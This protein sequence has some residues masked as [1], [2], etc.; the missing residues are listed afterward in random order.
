MRTELAR[1]R[2]RMVAEVTAAGRP[3]SAPVTEAL[4]VVA[5]HLFLP[6]MPPEVAYRDD[7]IVTRRG[8]DGQPTSSS[9]QPTIMAIMLDQLGLEPGQRVLEIGA[10]TGYNAALMKYLVGPSGT[11]V[12]VDLDQ[13]VAREAAAH[14]AAAGYPE[15][16]VAAGDGAEGYPAGA[17]YDR[18]IATVGVSDLAPAWLD[19]L[20]PDG[21]I[22]VPLDLRGS[23][24]SIAFERASEAGVAGG[25]P[26][27]DDVPG[28]WQSRSVVPCGFMRM[29]GSLAGPERTQVIGGHHE[30]SLTLPD[31][32]SVD[33]ATLA[34]NLEAP[35]GPAAEQATRVLAGPAQLF[36]GLGLWLALHEPR[37]GVL[38]DSGETGATALLR[39]PTSLHGQHVTAGVFDQAGSFAVL[40]RPEN[41]PPEPDGAAGPPAD[42]PAGRPGRRGPRA[43]PP[44]E[45]SVLGYG[46]DGVALTAGLAALLEAWDA[47]GRPGTRNFGVRAY[48]GGASDGAGPGEGE[49]VLVRPHTTFVVYPLDGPGGA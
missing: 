21:R 39:A 13:D 2:D 22:V 12:T 9:S 10:G 33:L 49:S 31:S 7:A 6:G 26:G 18:V 42:P 3:V 34:G 11:V 23:Q 41:Y 37:L 5:R 32:R 28:V 1:M 47:A 43:A 40:A 48:P 45:I 30:L 38:S 4:R 17:P 24:R 8:P 16:T 27:A 20:R 29:R 15:V 19:Q 36:D 35:G 44:F 46:P 14:L 25:A